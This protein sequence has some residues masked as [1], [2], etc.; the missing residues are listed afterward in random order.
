ML[1]PDYPPPLVGLD[2]GRARALAAFEEA[3]A[4]RA[5]PGREVSSRQGLRS[6][7]A[8]LRRDPRD[9]ARGE[10]DAWSPRIAARR[11]VPPGALGARGGHRHG[12]HRRSARRC[13]RARRRGRHRARDARPPASR[14]P[15]LPVLRR[16]DALA[17]QPRERST[18]CCSSTCCTCCADR[19]GGAFARRARRSRPGGV[20]LYGREEFP[21]S[22]MLGP[23]RADAR[24][25]R[26]ADG[27]ERRVALAARAGQRGVRGGRRARP[28]SSRVE[29]GGRDL[30]G[31]DDGPRAARAAWPAR[32]GRAP[33]TSPTRV[34]PEVLRRL[35]PRIEAL[36]GDL[37]R[38][39]LL[40]SRF[41]LAVA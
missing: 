31:T 1:C 18:R 40:R 24:A 38:T 9:S 35:T 5:R 11:R 4:R 15:E 41:T 30:G 27:V 14:R 17:V 34:M 16:C 10:R 28:A 19:R 12:T 20:L 39:V 3:R 29:I 37:D 6:R 33:G 13:R 36:L 2:E 26:R 32:S 25:G 22:P 7:R 21:A 8:L 23:S